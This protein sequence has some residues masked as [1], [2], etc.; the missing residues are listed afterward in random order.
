IAEKGDTEEREERRRRP[1]EVRQARDRRARGDETDAG[2]GGPD[3]P[4]SAAARSAARRNPYVARTLPAI[5]PETFERPAS[6]GSWD[7]RTSTIRARS[8][9]ALTTISTGQPN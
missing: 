4:T 1:D 9:A 6:R 5:V 2:E 7:T 3:H 8:A